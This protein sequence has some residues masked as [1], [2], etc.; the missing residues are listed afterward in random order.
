ML[1]YTYFQWKQLSCHL[2]GVNLHIFTVKTAQLP[3]LLVSTFCL[4]VSS[5][6]NLCKRFGPRSGLTKRR[7]WS[8]SNLFDTQMV[9]LK[10]FFENERFWKNQQT[11]KACKITTQ[12]GKRV[13][14]HLLI[15]FT[16]VKSPLKR[17]C[18][19]IWWVRGLRFCMTRSLLP[20]F[21]HAS[22]EGSGGTAR[23]LKLAWAIA[24]RQC[25]KYQN[26]LCW[27]TCESAWIPYF[28][29]AEREGSGGTARMLRLVWSIA[30]RR[31]RYFV[32]TL[33]SWK[34]TSVR[35]RHF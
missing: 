20:Y 10:E 11:T 4:L 3:P 24:A 28:V 25:D 19:A 23:M 7:A 32:L 1:T 2:F 6:A 33:A 31:W 34:P 29:Y 13:Y 5:A 35:A 26:F 30:A 9:A 8:G 12:G 15:V 21:V 16:C 22:S 14:L 18:A 17:A 27:P